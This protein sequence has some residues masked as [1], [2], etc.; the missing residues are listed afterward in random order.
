MKFKK[1]MTE[2]FITAKAEVVVEAKCLRKIMGSQ[3]EGM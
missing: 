3:T 1:Y 2:W